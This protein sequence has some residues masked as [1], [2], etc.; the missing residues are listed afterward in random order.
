MLLDTHA[1]ICGYA[2]ISRELALANAI[3]SADSIASS[4]PQKNEGLTP[5][6]RRAQRRA[7]QSCPRLGRGKGVSNG[8]GRVGG[9][10]R[11]LQTTNRECVADRNASARTTTCRR[12]V[13]TRDDLRR[14]GSSVMTVSLFLVSLLL[15]DDS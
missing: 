10:H 12:V 14:E 5:A 13:R 15:I 6:S 11:K 9:R 7:E 3:S 1:V 4:G 2:P 8:R